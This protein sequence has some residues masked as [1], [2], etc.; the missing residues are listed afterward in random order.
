MISDNV[1]YGDRIK[2]FVKIGGG[3]TKVNHGSNTEW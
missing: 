3:I 1:F 2:L